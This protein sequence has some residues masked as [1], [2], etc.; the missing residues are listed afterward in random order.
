MCSYLLDQEVLHG[1]AI[2]W[3]ELSSEQPVWLDL[4]AAAEISFDEVIWVK[5]L[6]SF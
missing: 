3:L 4:L 2:L 1:V 5:F 6:G